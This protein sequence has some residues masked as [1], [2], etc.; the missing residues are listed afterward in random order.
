MLLKKIPPMEIPQETIDAA[1]E[2]IKTYT[3]WC[4]DDWHSLSDHW[5]LHLCLDGDGDKFALI[6][7]VVDGNTITNPPEI[8]V[9][10][11][12]EAF[13]SSLQGGQIE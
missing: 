12:F 8:G 2:Y 9:L 13:T 10:V 6:Y 3:E 4:D 1:V 11:Y 7:P 5:D